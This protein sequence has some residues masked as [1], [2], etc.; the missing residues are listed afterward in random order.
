MQI[1]DDLAPLIVRALEH[2]AAFMRATNRDERP[3]LEI[4]E[5]LKRKGTGEEEPLR[6]AKK[7]RA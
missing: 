7:K 6:S 3:Y 4:A 2:Y 5:S 1:P